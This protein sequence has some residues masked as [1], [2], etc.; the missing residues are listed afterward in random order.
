MKLFFCTLWI[1]FS[2]DIW[3]ELK[4]FMFMLFYSIVI[5]WIVFKFTTASLV[6]FLL[7]L[8]ALLLVCFREFVN[9]FIGQWERARQ[10]ALTQ[11]YQ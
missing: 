1:Y 4:N 2:E 8:G 10:R 5:V 7:G 9:K 6:L 3:P 11:D